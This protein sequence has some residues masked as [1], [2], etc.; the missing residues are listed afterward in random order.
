MDP[1]DS[2]LD[3]D[4]FKK[5][6][7]DTSESQDAQ[8]MIGTFQAIMRPM[9]ARNR[10]GADE[11]QNAMALI[12]MYAYYFETALVILLIMQDAILFITVYSATK[13]I[14]H[15]IGQQLKNNSLV[16]QS[17]LVN[18]ELEIVKYFLS[19]CNILDLVNQSEGILLFLLI[20]GL[21]LY[22]FVTVYYLVLN[23]LFS[24]I[25]LE[26]I[27]QSINQALWLILHSSKLVVMIEP[28]HMLHEEMKNTKYLLSRLLC[29]RRRER[30]EQQSF[31]SPVR[32]ELSDNTLSLEIPS[33]SP[34][35]IVTFG[36]PLLATIAGA[37][38]TFF[39]IVTQFNFK[40]K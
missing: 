26:S 15:S 21:I 13:A 20:C 38:T 23:L 2:Q 35:G 36:R 40:A 18:M 28:C 10:D 4:D 22:I 37:V 3:R 24:D 31:L 12:C 33:F 1:V 7:R 30:V 25:S 17:N 14:N 8:M 39:L 29:R 34:I 19:I 16:Q 9:T 27:L 11:A 5:V 6:K 32:R